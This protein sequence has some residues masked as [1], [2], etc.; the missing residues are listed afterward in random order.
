MHMIG[1]GHPRKPATTRDL[2]VLVVDTGAD[3]SALV[4]MLRLH[5]HDAR[6][7]YGREHALAIAEEWQP[8]AAVLGI[9]LPGMDVIELAGRLGQTALRPLLL[10]AVT[11]L[12]NPQDI[13]MLKES[14]FDYV[15]RKRADPA[16]LFHVLDVHAE[17]R[18]AET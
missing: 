13:G 17:R 16:A 15:F 18:T 1:S 9:E 7:A 4:W 6:A 10:V 8:D 2:S 12:G 11:G 3:A 14:P 5:G